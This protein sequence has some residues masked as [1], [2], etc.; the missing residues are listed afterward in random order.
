MTET[1][2]LDRAS[3]EEIYNNLD[4]YKVIENLLEYIYENDFI[5]GE[6]FACIDARN[7]KVVYD[8]VDYGMVK[9]YEDEPSLTLIVEVDALEAKEAFINATGLNREKEL[10]EEYLDIMHIL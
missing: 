9:D 8:C 6:A 1:K 5:T 2:I 3:I 7:G 4:M 10:I